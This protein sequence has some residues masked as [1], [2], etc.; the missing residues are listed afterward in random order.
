VFTDAKLAGANFTAANLSRAKLGG[1]DLAGVN[2]TGAYLLL[3]QLGGADLS[4]ATGLAQP[5]V[6][7]A[8]GTAETKLPAE[9][10]PPKSWPC[11]EE[12]E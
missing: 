1:L 7:L 12:E 9:L 3:T 10:S 8:C 6:D 4:R 11:A 2:L 5:Q